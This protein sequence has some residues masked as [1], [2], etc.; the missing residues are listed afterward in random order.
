MSNVNLKWS[1][2]QKAFYSEGNIGISNILNK[3][4]NGAFEGFLEIRRTEDGV[5]AFNLFFK[6][7]GDSWYYFG[8]EGSRLLVHAANNEFNSMI[9]KRTNAGKTKIG[10][11]AFVPGSDEETLAFI[12]RFRKDYYGIESPYS[13]GSR[14][15]AVP[16]N[17]PADQTNQAP[18]QTPDQKQPD[19]PI[20]DDGF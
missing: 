16:V 5:S 18:S 17:E 10:E 12:N 11:I 19:K 4:I 1:D 15:M 2:K 6:A 9:I 14:S 20:E 8:F 13:L 3:D 7:S